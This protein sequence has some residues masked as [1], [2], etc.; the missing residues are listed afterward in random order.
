RGEKAPKVLRA[1]LRLRRRKA[2][3][4]QLAK[5]HADWQKS[6]VLPRLTLFLFIIRQRRPQY[7][8]IGFRAA[9]RFAGQAD[10]YEADEC[11]LAAARIAEQDQP[12]TTVELGERRQAL[13]ESVPT[14]TRGN[15]GNLMSAREESRIDGIETHPRLAIPAGR[16]GID[17]RESQGFV[18]MEDPAQIGMPQGFGFGAGL[19]SGMEMEIPAHGYGASG[20]GALPLRQGAGATDGTFLPA[21]HGPRIEA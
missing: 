10:S 19:R 6:F 16:H 15:L 18:L 20:D 8:Q 21:T 2:A 11:A 12:W 5:N 13:Q 14:S 9:Q 4:R 3:R 7:L 1:G 17:S